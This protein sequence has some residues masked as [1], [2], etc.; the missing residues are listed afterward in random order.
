MWYVNRII[1]NWTLQINFVF[2]SLELRFS[3]YTIVVAALEMWYDI[4]LAQCVQ[5]KRL[6]DFEFDIHA[7]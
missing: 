3:I 6:F 5:K 4:Y 7:N 1:K 2:I